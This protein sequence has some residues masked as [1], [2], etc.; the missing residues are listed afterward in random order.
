MVGMACNDVRKSRVGEE[1]EGRKGKL[2][3]RRQ[4]GGFSYQQEEET[5]E[6]LVHPLNL[7]G[8]DQSRKDE[9]LTDPSQ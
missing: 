5:E 2:K 9:D 1:E 4:R 3:R 6:E 7:P 8:G